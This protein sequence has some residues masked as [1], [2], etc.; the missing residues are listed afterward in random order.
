MHKSLL[1][2]EPDSSERRLLEKIFSNDYAL[3][4]ADTA[5]KALEI[6]TGTPFAVVVFNMERAG[7]E[8]F[9]GLN[10]LKTQT[11]NNPIIIVLTTYNNLEIEKSIAAIGVFYHLLKPYA[12]KD[13][14]DLVDAAFL[15][16]HR[17]YLL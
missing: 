11:S 6:M 17:K 3:I 4:F 2:I 5:T 12:E 14:R 16:W 8:S 7:S 1:V 13:L 9:R 10:I 15:E